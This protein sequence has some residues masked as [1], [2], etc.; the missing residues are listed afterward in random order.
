MTHTQPTPRPLT[1]LEWDYVSHALQSFDQAAL[2]RD[3]RDSS[4]PR[5]AVEAIDDDLRVG[6]WPGAACAAA[7]RARRKYQAE[8]ERRE[9]PEPLTCDR[10]L[11]RGSMRRHCGGTLVR[12]RT[13]SG[14]IHETPGSRYQHHVCTACGETSMRIPAPVPAATPEPT[15]EPTPSILVGTVISGTHRTQDLIPAFLETLQAVDPAG[16][17]QWAF[18][19]PFGIV[20][21]YAQED[22]DSE[23]W[24]SDDAAWTVEALIEALDA[25]APAELYFG[26]HEADGADYGFWVYQVD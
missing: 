21:G 24:S 18:T 10:P 26:A 13:R 17:T 4:D 19:A 2:T 25:A 15:P 7:R 20:P 1:E 14:A 3:P 16:Y 22:P 11:R 8:A 23:W 5:A 12:A 9:R 6:A